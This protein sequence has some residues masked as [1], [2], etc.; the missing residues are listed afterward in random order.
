MPRANYLYLQHNVWKA[1]IWISYVS[2]SLKCWASLISFRRISKVHF[3][4]L[5]TDFIANFILISCSY[6]TISLLFFRLLFSENAK[7]LGNKRTH[8]FC[9]I[10]PFKLHNNRFKQAIDHK[11]WWRIEQCR[12]STYQTR[13]CRITLKRG[14]ADLSSL[15]A[16][17]TT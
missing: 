16:L 4:K 9:L 11:K 5:P 15:L 8:S 12:V 10:W 1:F 17:Q 14:N 7:Y 3:I 13:K 6:L 2:H